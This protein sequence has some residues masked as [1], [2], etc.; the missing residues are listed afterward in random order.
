MP[1]AALASGQLVCTAPPAYLA[2]RPAP[3]S[4]ASLGAS[5]ATSG[6]AGD[7]EAGGGGVV[8]GVVE[9]EV[10]TNG[11]ADYTSRRLPFAHERH[12]RALTHTQI[13]APA[14][15]QAHT[16]AHPHTYARRQLP[17]AY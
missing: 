7:G 13:H 6:V 12:A 11:G 8:A 1:A 17:L 9:V 14:A 15:A 16:R 5:A 10:S 2:L 4:A 3:P